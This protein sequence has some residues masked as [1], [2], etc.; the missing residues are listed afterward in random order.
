MEDVLLEQ[1]ASED[2]GVADWH[3]GRPDSPPD[4][5]PSM[6]DE[7]SRLGM[8]VAQPATGALRP[9]LL[10]GLGG[11]GRRALLEL[12]CRFLDRFGDLEKTPLVRFLYIDVDGEAVKAATHGSPEVALKPAE[13]YHLP[14]QA[15]S[16]YRRRQLDF[17]TD[18]LPREKLYTMPRS[19]KTAG[20]ARPRPAGLRRQ[21]P[22]SHGP[23]PPRG[24]AGHAPRRPIPVRQQH[25]PGPPR[26]HAA[27]LRPGGGRRR[28]ER[29]PHRPRLRPAS[30]PQADAP[31]RGAG[32]GAGLLRRPGRPGHAGPG[33][34]QR[35]R[36]AHRAEPLRRPL[37]PL[38]R[39]VR[40][41]RA[42]PVRRGDGLR[43]PLC[44][45]ARQPLAGEP[46]RR[47]RPPRQLPVPRADHAA[48]SSPRQPAAE[49]SGRRL[50]PVPQS[51]DL[52][53]LVP[54]RSAAAPGCPPGLPAAA[55]TVAGA[56]QG[57]SFAGRRRR[58]CWRRLRRGCWP[59]RSCCR[60][61]CR[62]GSARRPP[63]P[64]KASLPRR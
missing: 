51:G 10:I 19:L 23:L 62:G 15:V 1:M 21:L 57:R 35:L 52:R 33:A 16:H 34:G 7:Q 5:D 6:P 61:A 11:F 30:P 29:L 37:R 56:G 13:V 53:D 55:G 27:R 18:W 54:A 63:S 59:T 9:T 28:P 14:L 36:H 45:A 50:G 20:I 58:S 32:D 39:P 49:A 41:G 38:R 4:V 17:L 46:P 44:P 40:R 47:P 64:R 22:S 25:R 26:R 2:D 43:Q 60:R 8:T 12:R 48:R 3:A 31:A 24:A 42:A